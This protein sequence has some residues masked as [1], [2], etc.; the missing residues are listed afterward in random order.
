MQLFR[1]LHQACTELLWAMSGQT[2]LRRERLY[3]LQVV[4]KQKPQQRFR[5]SSQTHCVY[6]RAEHSVC[7][8]WRSSVQHLHLEN[9]VTTTPLASRGHLDFLSREAHLFTED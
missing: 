5:V 2:F 9:I 6:L 4:T 7:N 3:K 8:M 1:I